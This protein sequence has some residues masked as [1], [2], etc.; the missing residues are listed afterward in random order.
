MKLLLSLTP[1][2]LIF[3][4][5][6]LK[7][8]VFS[9]TNKCLHPKYLN[10]VCMTNCLFCVCR[11]VCAAAG[12]CLPTVPEGQTDPAGVPDSVLP[13]SLCRCWSGFPL[14]HL[15]DLHR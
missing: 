8:P 12:L 2:T 13:G 11:R 10:V 4:N 15:P 3:Q 14:C 6:F 7:F 9:F 1:N 5:Q